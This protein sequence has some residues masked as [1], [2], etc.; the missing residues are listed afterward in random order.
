MVPFLF[1]GLVTASDDL[2]EKDWVKLGKIQ[3]VKGVSFQRNCGAA[4]LGVLNLSYLRFS[5]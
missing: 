2:T 1:K 5:E 4:S 3:N